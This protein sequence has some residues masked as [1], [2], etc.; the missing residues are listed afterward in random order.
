MLDLLREIV[1]IDSGTYDKAG[2]DALGAVVQHFL[3]GQGERTCTMVACRYQTI[4][5]R[6]SSAYIRKSTGRRSVWQRRGR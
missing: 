2:I 6:N 3:E 5:S 1:V 4:G